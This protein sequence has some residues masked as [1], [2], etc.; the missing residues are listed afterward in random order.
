MP[1]L[2]PAIRKARLDARNRTSGA[3]RKVSL[4]LDFRWTSVPV[5]T[6]I[7][8]TRS[9]AVMLDARVSL[10]SALETSISQESNAKFRAILSDIRAKVKGGSSLSESLSLHPKVF[11]TYYVHMVEV[12]ELAGVLHQVL[13]RLA[14]SMSKRYVLKKKI[15]AAMIYPGVIMGVATGAILFLLLVIVPTFAEMYRDFGA[16]LPWLTQF[17]LSASSW[18]I[19]NI[20]VIL[21]SVGIMGIGIKKL[22]S[23]YQVRYRVDRLL[24]HIPILGPLLTQNSV[25]GFC[26]TLGTLLE[27][28]V[29]LTDALRIMQK[30][31]GNL[32]MKES[33]KQMAES[34]EKGGSLGMAVSRSTIYPQ[35]VQQMITVGEETSELDRMLLHLA[36]YYREEI[37]RKVEG[38]T[39][40]IEPVLIVIIGIIL[41]FL[42]VA[43]YL[44]MF[45][46]MNAIN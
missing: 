14:D 2:P 1:T 18:M 20:V 16:E 37:D 33:I 12:G 38:I 29:I 31:S 17:I 13:G 36:G 6:V 25:A 21:I 42:I 35:A 40:I 45:E 10:V 26:Q 32:V 4:R 28:G 23:L 44:P 24:F 27:S 34:I 7:D 30:A 22:L 46:L 9:L 8:F 3:T 41:G 11:D 19:G 43:M 15:R 39:S 5:K